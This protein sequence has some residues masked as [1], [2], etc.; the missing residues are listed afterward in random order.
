M[1]LAV[2][3]AFAVEFRDGI[4]S[5]ALGG[6]LLNLA[7][8]PFFWIG[9]VLLFLGRRKTRLVTGLVPPESTASR[10]TP[11]VAAG[12]GVGASVRAQLADNLRD[13]ILKRAAELGQQYAN[14]V[15]ELGDDAVAALRTDL[16]RSF[17]PA[18]V[19]DRWME[20]RP[21]LMASRPRGGPDE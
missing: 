16:E 18:A 17:G 7:L 1:A 8:S 15:S 9:A 14:E 11:S 5:L 3:T 2:L 10:V 20:I 4:T 19:A 6:F 21:L 12:P 13:A